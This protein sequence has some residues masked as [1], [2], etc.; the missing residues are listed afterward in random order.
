MCNIKTFDYPVC[1]ECI[2]HGVLSSLPEKRGG[3]DKNLHWSFENAGVFWLHTNFISDVVFSDINNTTIINN[4]CVG[5]HTITGYTYKQ[6]VRITH[7]KKSNL[8]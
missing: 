1:P 3:P 5:G 8:A 2:I 7:R 4:Q 6:F